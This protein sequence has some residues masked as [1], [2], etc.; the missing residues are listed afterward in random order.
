MNTEH[1][2]PEL[3]AA[4]A[5][6]QSEVENATK[7]STNPHFKS[8]YADLAEVLNTVRPTFAKHG[9]SLLQSTAFEGSLVSVT[10]VV[11]HES[12]GHVSSVASCVPAK[13][14]A[15]GIGAATTYLRRYGLAAMTG[16]A[17]EDD[18]GAGASHNR[19]P[20]P[21]TEARKSSAQAKRDGDWEALKQEVD[22]CETLQAAPHRLGGPP[23]GLRAGRSRRVRG[24]G[25]WQSPGA[26]IN[27]SPTQLRR[28][29][30][31]SLTP[32]ARGSRKALGREFQMNRTTLRQF[33]KSLT[34]GPAEAALRRASDIAELD[35]A[36]EDYCDGFAD[37]SQEREFLRGLYDE[38]K[39]HMQQSFRAAEMMRV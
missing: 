29:R 11:A 37:E 31:H 5:K 18:D 25:H 39:F 15:Q 2:T 23:Q 22:A 36:W 12:G 32:R 38:R 24:A 6:A 28:T 1:A 33:R 19:E 3:F 34:V 10:T 20:V 14:D 30:T 9:L 21:V 26:G 13:S 7:G 35:E 8:K 4:I 27:R 17:Q 16:V